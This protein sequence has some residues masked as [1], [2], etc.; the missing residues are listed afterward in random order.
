MNVLARARIEAAFMGKD[1]GK[2]HMT[3]ALGRMQM[4]SGLPLFAP[5]SVEAAE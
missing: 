1:E 3:S 4:P 2:R 5:P